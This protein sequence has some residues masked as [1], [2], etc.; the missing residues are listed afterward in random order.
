MVAITIILT[1]IIGVSF[2]LIDTISNRFSSSIFSNIKNPKIKFFFNQ[3]ES[4]ILK[5]KDGV[6][7]K[8]ER[9]FGSTTILSFITDAWHLFKSLIIVSIFLLAVFESY[10]IGIWYVDIA[11]CFAI[12]FISFELCFRNFFMKKYN[13]KYFIKALKI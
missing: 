12:Y 6:P 10:I 13:K 1:I 5:Y 8:G 7:K 11:I 3:K 4:W 9:F 2:A